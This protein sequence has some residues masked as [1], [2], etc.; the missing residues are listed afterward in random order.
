MPRDEKYS[1]FDYNSNCD[2]C[3]EWYVLSLDVLVQVDRVLAGNGGVVVQ[4]GLL[5]LRGLSWHF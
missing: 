2:G 5:G 3:M 4:M 1:F